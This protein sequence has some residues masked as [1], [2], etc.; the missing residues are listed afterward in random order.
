MINMTDLKY[1]IANA[2]N[3]IMNKK[4]Q[5]EKAKDTN[6][7]MERMKS[8]LNDVTTTANE[9][10]TYLRNL[11]IFDRLANQEDTNYKTRRLDYLSTYIEDNL[12]II[13]PNE[14]FK[15]K[16]D[17]D[18]KYKSSK[19][20]LKLQ[21]K[22]GKHRLPS[23]AEGKLCQELISFSSAVAITDCMGISGFYLDEAFAAS[24]PENLTKAGKL[25][26]KLIESGYQILLIEQKD[27]IYKDLPRNEIHLEKSPINDE[28]IV[29][30]I[31]TY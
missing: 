1:I 20:Q 21:P 12:A 23:I 4:I 14:Q 24:S 31:V 25:L 30:D 26:H 19:A 7:R 6:H 28:V 3:D 15:C 27:D 29:K 10:E 11:E 18:Y 9:L 16:I 17:Y 13:F 5:L 8:D 22:S 2:E